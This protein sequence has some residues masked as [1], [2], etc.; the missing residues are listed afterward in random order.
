MLN[1]GRWRRLLSSDHNREFLVA[2]AIDEVHC[3][4]HWGV[5]TAEVKQASL[6][7]YQWYQNVGEINSLLSNDVPSFVLKATP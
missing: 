5:S 3:I 6:P 1:S 2:V 7:F 4:S